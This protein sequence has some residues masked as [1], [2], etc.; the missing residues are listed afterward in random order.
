[1]DI[2][3]RSGR[4][5]FVCPNGCATEYEAPVSKPAESAAKYTEETEPAQVASAAG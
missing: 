3:D 1:M 5:W 4:P 2:E